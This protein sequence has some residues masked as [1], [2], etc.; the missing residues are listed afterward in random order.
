ME[1][2]RRRKRGNHNY[3]LLTDEN[4]VASTSQL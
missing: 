2:R 3:E 4:S 1:G